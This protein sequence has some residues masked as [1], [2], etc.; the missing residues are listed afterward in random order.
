MGDKTTVIHTLSLVPKGFELL[1]PPQMILSREYTEA[2]G[3]NWH[4][5]H[6]CCTDCDDQLHNK[7]ST[8]HEGRVICGRCFAKYAPNC[9]RCKEAIGV[10]QKKLSVKGR[11]YHRGCFVCKRCREDLVEER[12]SVIDDDIICSDCTKPVSQC[13]GCKEGISPTVS[14]LKHGTR[15]WHADC[16]KCNVCRAWLVD[17]HFHEMASSVMCNSCYVEKM[18]P[19]CEACSK[20]IAEKGIQFSL[21]SYHMDC[22]VCA[23]C[24]EPLVGQNGKVKEKNGEPYCQNCIAKTYKKCFK[25]R[26]A[27]S[28]RH[29]VYN[30]HPFHLQCFQCNKC[31]R[32]IGAGDFFETSLGEILCPRCI[33]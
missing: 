15:S 20:P 13:Q 33:E 28:T 30:G 1:F 4:K 10:G 6:Y 3:Q 26:G 7:S 5:E 19:K 31:G 27:I 22:F 2:A 8:S 18:S 21:K 14:Y 23:S 9:H 29:T 32:S 11:H 17:G 16:F 24:K 12:Y 25:C